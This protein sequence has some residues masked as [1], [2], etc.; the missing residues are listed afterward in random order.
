MPDHGRRST[1]RRSSNTRPSALAVMPK[2]AAACKIT[3]GSWAVVAWTA[4]PMISTPPKNPSQASRIRQVSRSRR[5]WPRNTP[6]V[7]SD[8]MPI[9]NIEETLRIVVTGR[10]T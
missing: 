7:V 6:D 4:M 1:C 8:V 10:R 9:P 2:P 3:G 5:S